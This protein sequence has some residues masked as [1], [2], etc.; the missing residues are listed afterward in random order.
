ME[1]LILIGLLGLMTLSISVLELFWM[2]YPFLAE[3]RRLRISSNAYQNRV[4]TMQVSTVTPAVPVEAKDRRE[5]VSAAKQRSRQ[6][7]A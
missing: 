6:L 4:A 2:W 7:A 3:R 5:D 1:L